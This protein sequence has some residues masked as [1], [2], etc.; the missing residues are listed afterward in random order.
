MSE[1][2]NELSEAI[3]NVTSD[4]TQEALW[5]QIED[6]AGQLD[7]PES[8]AKAF[9]SCLQ[10]D[11]STDDAVQLGQRAVNFHR[12]WFG[13]DPSGLATLLTRILEIDPKNEWA[14]QE[15]T[16]ALT[17]A[18]R[19]D[20]V[21]KLYQDVIANTS[22]K[23]RLIRLLDEAYQVAKD[24][25][26]RPDQAIDFLK[27]K[28]ELKPSAKQLVAL[29]RLLERHERW[30][31]LIALW[32]DALDSQSEDEQTETRTNIAAT[33]F[34]QLSAGPKAL[35]SLREIFSQNQSHES[36][37]A[38]LERIATSETS[39]TQL[40]DATLATV[41]EVYEATDRPGDIVRV[42]DEVLPLCDDNQRKGLHAEL[43]ERL[44]A[45]EE[46]SAALDHYAALLIL[47]PSSVATQR[48]LRREAQLTD[49]LDR[50][51][52][53]LA[54]AAD[55]ATDMS[56]R[57]ALLSEAAITLLES[58]NGEQGAIDL[59]LSAIATEGIRPA[60]VLNVGKRL[61]L[62]LD[63][64][65][66]QSERL[67][68]LERLA[69]A[70]SVES[71]R[72]A[73]IGDAAILAESLGEVD[74]A[75]A[76][77]KRRIE[78][79]AGDRRA[80]EHLI[81]LLGSEKRWPELIEA[82]NARRQQAVPENQKRSDLI[83]IANIY[84]VDLEQ[85]EQALQAWSEV[86]N[87]YGEDPEVIAA[88]SRLMVALENWESLTALLEGSNAQQV[89]YLADQFSNLGNAY[90]QSLGDHAKAIECYRRALTVDLGHEGAREGLKL[91]LDVPELRNEVAEALVHSMRS[92]GDLVGLLD[93]VE[94]R[95][96]GT[97]DV[98][99]HAEIL[100]EA[101][102]IAEDQAQD[103]AKALEFIT[104]LF[105]MTARDRVLEDRMVRLARSCE[106]WDGALAAYAQAQE[107]IS[108][109][110]FALAAMRFRE[111]SVRENQL[112]D[113]EGALRN[114]LMV[115][116]AQP[117]NHDAVSATIRLA[118]PAGRMTDMVSAMLGYAS[119]R[120]A[121]P[122]DLLSSIVGF[123]EQG[124]EGC[125]YATLCSTLSNQ[126]SE[127]ELGASYK[128]ELHWR[129]AGWQQ[130]QLE[131]NAAALESLLRSTELDKG[132]VDTLTKLAELQSDGHDIALY[133]TIRRLCEIDAGNLSHFQDAAQL[134]IEVL[135]NDEQQES[136]A[137]LQARAV[138]A[139]RGSAPADSETPAQEIV[140][141]TIEKLVAFYVANEQAQ[142]ALDL[143]IDASRLPFDEATCLDM[144]R[145][146]AT[147]ASDVLQDPASAID[148]YRAVLAQSPGDADALDA[149]GTLYEQQ[150]RLPELLGLK[151]Q[152]LQFEDDVERS[153]AMRL[154]VA[155]LIDEIDRKGGRLELLQQN[156][157]ATPGHDASVEALTTLLSGMGK[158]SHLCELLG[159]QAQRLEGQGEMPRAAQLWTHI[160]GI[161]ETQLGDIDQ[162][163]ESFRKVA[164]L[165]PNLHA[166]D[167]LARLYISRS[168]SGAAVPWLEQALDLAA[169]SD[170][171]SLVKRL[172]QAHLA[173]GH[174]AD[175]IACLT[176]ATNETESS[177]LEL[178]T[179]LA[180]L[181]RDAE[182]WQ[183]LADTLTASLP[184]IEG[185][186]N[187]AQ[188]AREA[189]NIYHEKLGTPAAAVPAL[190]RA[191]NIVPEDRSLR[192]MMARSQRVAGDVQAARGLLEA[193]IAEFGRRRSQERA[194]I[195]VEL[196]QVA[197]A[198]SDLDAAMA[199]LELASKMDGS[200]AHILRALAELASEQG[201]FD[202]A[203]R[204]LRA[205][206]LIVRR[207]P[208]GED[209]KAVGISEVLFE[210]H[211]IAA[212]RDDEEKAEELLESVVEAASSSDA[213]VRRLRRTLLEHQE[214]ELLAKVLRARIQLSEDTTSKA[215]LLGFVA[216]LLEGALDDRSAALDAR[217][218][219]LALLPYDN[220]LHERAKLLATSLNKLPTY[221]ETLEEMVAQQ[222]RAEE[223]D[224]TAALLM[225]AGT[226][227]ETELDDLSKAREHFAAAEEC[228]SA[229]A[230]ALFALARVCAAQGD[231]EEQTRA[232]DK[233]TSLA[234]VDGP[235]AAQADALYRLAELQVVQP[236]LVE[237][238][239]ELLTKA[240]SVEPR[241]RQAALTL[242]AA[243]K[244]SQNDPTVLSHYES[245][246]RQSGDKP[247]LLD[248]LERQ[249]AGEDASVAQ[250][251][252][253]VNLAS[254]LEE[255]E[256]EVALLERAVQA[257]RVSD[258]GLSSAIWAA[259]DLA[260]HYG[261]ANRVGDAKDLLFEIAYLASQDEIMS[262]GL[263][264]AE[265]SKAAEDYAMTAEILEFLRGRDPNLRAV[266]E[267]LLSLYRE[268]GSG[269]QLAELVDATL[270][271]L[272]DP[273][274]R[275]QLRLHKAQ[276]L[277]DSNLDDDAINV[278][279][280]AC[281]DDPDSLDAAGL[282]ETVL[283]KEGNEEALSDFLWQRFND[284]KER[285]NPE[286]V[287]DV[288]VRLGAL[289]DQIDGDSM[290]VFQQAL[291]VA[292]ESAELLR[293][294]LERL[295]DN[296]DFG[297]QAALTER[298]LRVESPERA[299]DLTLALVELREVLEDDD[300]VQR[301]L[302]IG[303]RTCPTHTAIRERL[304]GLYQ[305][306]SQWGPLA[307]MK[308]NQAEAEEVV[309]EQVALYRQAGA[310]YRDSLSDLNSCT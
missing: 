86:R 93:I 239:I 119:A 259:T 30:T 288:A 307:Q 11:L 166:L 296:A 87:Q 72:R 260:G 196:A 114:V 202:Q 33:Y 105:P 126:L 34:D 177:L 269:E 22:N 104:Q 273:T 64:S 263:Q 201:D 96:A 45:L 118:G 82:L 258:D 154:E 236:D 31:D 293:G 188:A 278:L 252:E 155:A 176:V 227:A 139:W 219:C 297:E 283:R 250:I 268:T 175:A 129:I 134:A 59:L 302:E 228:S 6:L 170:R 235:V 137:A 270:P 184:F 150:G 58:P 7:D 94:A 44:S 56:R 209:E 203:E 207:H 286:T 19:W 210:L 298:L 112:S 300:G 41:R 156:L 216:D 192:L 284:A 136:L 5:D 168:Q 253:A 222:R 242:Q 127:T 1:P 67:T 55:A 140:A 281:L 180:D 80:L 91:L 113:T 195:H 185:D 54:A 71:S 194:A 164:N 108:E 264:L 247:I 116:S 225:R 294:I 9:Q 69:D 26:N 125:D 299:G 122:E 100:R 83:R 68:V 53:A 40:R 218:Q 165:A 110:S 73:L 103:N 90:Q 14:F 205:L 138:A 217:L 172:A 267:P 301:A 291:Q 79:D 109:D 21:I 208:P 149:L 95:I 238:G 249:A 12:E 186:E 61:N 161:A 39:D 60:D 289:L 303:Q 89:A 28:L 24:L 10:Q 198:E 255:R 174:S 106:S 120:Q 42:L 23:T 179:M 204:S 230:D 224:L 248:Y 102:D 74:R 152:G 212:I 308:I 135:G 189:A 57:V 237:R 4:P 261:S 3:A 256:R 279:R 65:E 157:E 292:P 51:A 47:D 50:F 48:A 262:L 77:W 206:L 43:G 272:V 76:A 46:H 229:P 160:A 171:P 251:R 214:N 38:L 13:D 257:A 246:A 29:E 88:L 290:Q 62:L 107:I 304:E 244:S 215:E 287:T 231:T 128:A 232:L 274:E 92:S 193:L 123:A 99:K 182:Q 197:R 234:M 305:E 280:D 159:D 25:A 32:T 27:A 84:E 310:L 220:Q 115:V 169:E 162:A 233:L 187:I 221:L 181:H 145:R 148:M 16:V 243:A 173:A 98:R 75:L 200:N 226:L 144:R 265:S 117:D 66:R 143:L 132:R 141:W 142:R 275:T 178:R 63:R 309:S 271:S 78:S 213:E 158:F 245:A 2:Q 282:L 199:E 121:I 49:R 295:D 240:L 276:Y 133:R 8:V 130:S 17:V 306:T 18:E 153:M 277:I 167:S 266:W 211:H 147:I 20:D 191:L 190:A 52:A 70:E 85:P 223:A 131:D 151:R 111:V 37:L 15:L 97:D 285:G 241:Y 146:A 101:A 81:E 35:D 254:E 36:S 163:L 124:I 183:A